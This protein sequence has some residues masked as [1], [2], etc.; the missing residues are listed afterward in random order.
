MIENLKIGFVGAGNMGSA[1]IGGLI[2]S[3]K[4]QPENIYACDLSAGKLLPLKDMGVRTTDNSDIVFGSCDVVILAVKP[5]V[6][7]KLLPT[8]KTVQPIFV[9]IAAGISVNFIKS[10]LPQGAKVV[11]VMPNTPALIGKG[12]TVIS[13]APE[14]S[15]SQ[16]ATVREIFDCVG[17]T[18]IMD[19]S[20]MDAVVSASGSSPAYVYMMIEAMADAAV[21]AGMPRQAACKICAAAVEGSAAMVLHT[22]THPGQL[23]DMVCSPGGTTID[24]VEALEA[25]GFRYAVMDAMAKCTEKSKILTK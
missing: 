24:A 25:D 18:E 19:E 20:L 13:P 8:V 7:P 12:V 16:A 5:N 10:N 14:I 17:V 23:K 4:A 9:S 1:I 11:R 2:A 3:K 22:G 21:K 6:F 15:D